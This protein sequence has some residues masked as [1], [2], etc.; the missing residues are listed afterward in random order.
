MPSA[1]RDTRVEP[2]RAYAWAAAAAR[3]AARV[4]AS[5][6][7]AADWTV[8]GWA[9]IALG[10]LVSG[11]A[12]A[13][14][15]LDDAVLDSRTPCNGPYAAR[16]RALRRIAG[17]VPSWYFAD[18]PS[19]LRAPRLAEDVATSCLYIAEFCDALDD[20]VSANRRVR[21]AEDGLPPWTSI[22]DHLRWGERFRPSLRDRRYVVCDAAVH[23][24][25]V[26][27]TWMR[28]PGVD[29]SHVVLACPVGTPTATYTQRVQ[30]GVHNGAHLDHLLALDAA[31]RQSPCFPVEIEFGDGLMVAEAYAM[32]VELLAAAECVLAGRAMEVRQLHRGL[33]SRIGR[34]PGYR[35]WRPRCGSGPQALDLALPTRVDEFASL[36]TLA[37]QYIIGPLRLIAADWDHRLLPAQLA[38]MARRRWARVCGRFEPAAA[39]SRRALELNR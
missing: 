20:A 27:R 21:P 35:L 16:L 23:P 22:A 14:Q 30:Q 18:E 6:R 28:L 29:E 3:S 33:V 1:V 25:L 5:G 11:A 31:D 17:E 26:R 9:E 37:G 15:G 7:E 38:E 2:D 10:C 13:I 12:E 8:R 34:T 32:S 36:P 39:L 19:L 4:P 24:R